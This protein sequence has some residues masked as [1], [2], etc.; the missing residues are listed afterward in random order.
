VLNRASFA[1]VIPSASDPTSC[2]SWHG[3]C[4][5]SWR[6][7]GAGETAIKEVQHPLHSRDSVPSNF[8]AQLHRCS[9]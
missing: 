9:I 3:K 7:L 5:V 1:T 6:R 4:G 2:V 8:D